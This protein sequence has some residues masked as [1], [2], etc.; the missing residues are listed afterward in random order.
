[1]RII[2]NLHIREKYHLISIN[3]CSFSKALNQFWLGIRMTWMWPGCD[4][5][6]TWMWPGCDL[7]MLVSRPMYVFVSNTSRCSSFMPKCVVASVGNLFA[8]CESVGSDSTL[9]LEH[10]KDFGQVRFV[11]LQSLLPCET[12]IIIPLISSNPLAGTGAITSKWRLRILSNL[13]GQYLTLDSAVI[14]LMCPSALPPNFNVEAA[15]LFH[16]FFA[17]SILATCRPNIE[18]RGRGRGEKSKVKYWPWLWELSYHPKQIS[19]CLHAHDIC[20]PILTPCMCVWA[21]F[22]L[23]RHKCQLS[24]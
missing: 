17:R 21:C 11:T 14:G 20:A 19:A 6:V 9:E 4:L 13:L 15:I 7:V 23:M 2:V 8:T 18:F 16:F 1:M 3:S 5:V 24:M 10:I 22:Q 12:N